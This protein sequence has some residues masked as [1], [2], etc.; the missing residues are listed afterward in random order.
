MHFLA[1][2]PICQHFHSG[3]VLTTT[4]SDQN[5]IKFFTNELGVQKI[6]DIWISAD[7][8]QARE[9]DHLCETQSLNNSNLSTG[10]GLNKKLQF[11]NQGEGINNNILTNDEGI[12]QDLDHYATSFF[13]KVLEKFDKNLIIFD[14]DLKKF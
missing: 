4:N 12:L 7:L 9:D 10:G 6:K 13:L 1:L 11:L 2:H 3:S 8:C 14:F 5:I